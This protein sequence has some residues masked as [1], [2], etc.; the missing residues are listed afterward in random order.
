[1]KK[2]FNTI[3][4]LLLLQTASYAQ[5][6]A[7]RTA[8]TKIADVLAQQPAAEQS[9]F[10]AAMKELEG[11]TTEDVVTLL[12][13]LK[14]QGGNNASIE[15]ATNSYAFYVMQPGRDAL[16]EKY[17]KGLLSALSDLK[18]QN[19]KAYVFELLKF[20]AKNESVDQVATYLT[21]A[22]FAEKAARVLSAI[23]TPEAAL[24]LNK[25]LAGNVTEQTATAIIGALGELQSKEAEERVIALIG[26]YQ[27]ENFQRNALTTLSKIGGEK[28]YDTF[29]G[30]AKSANFAFD[31][32]NVA[33]LTL[34]YANVLAKNGHKD[35]AYKLSSAVFAE[36]ADPKAIGAQVAALE[37][38]SRLEPKKQKKNLL[39]LSTGDNVVLRNVALGLLGD[40]ATASDLKRIASSL[41]KLSPESQESVLSFLKK[42]DATFAIPVIEKSLRGVKD[43][44]ARIAAYNTLSA[45]TKGANT[46]FV[47]SQLATAS[48]KEVE[49]LK[50]LL[51]TAK[52]DQV[53]AEINKALPGADDKTK[54]AL[55][56]VLSKRSDKNS[57]KAVF[58]LIE[59]GSPEVR[60]AAYKA[61]PNVVND[62]DF[63][64]V[65]HVMGTAKGAEVKPAQSAAIVALRNNKD[66]TAI[67]QRLS[68]NISRSQAPSAARLFPV[69]AG[70]GGE[71][72]LKTV[73]GYLGTNNPLKGDAIRALAG[74][75]NASSL[76][77]L[78]TLLRTEKDATLFKDI[79]TGF[80]KQLNASKVNNE[81]KTLLLRDAFEYAQTKDQRSAALSGLKSTGTYPALIFASK[82]LNDA[83]L[84]GVA[85]DVV[86]NII[87]DN[88]EFVGTDVRNW[89][90][91]AKNNLSGSESS[92]LKEAI[93][94]HLTEMPAKEG[95]VALFNGKDLTGWKGLVENPIKRAKMTPKEL[96]QKQ[97]EADKKMRESWSA[98]DGDLVFS[99]HGDNIATVKQYGDFELLLDWKLDKNGKEPDAGV[100]LRGTPQVQIWDIS[101]TNVGAQVGSGGL[102][103]NKSNSKPLKVADNPLGEWNN[104]K[105]R[106]VGEDVSVWLNGELVVDNVPLENYWDRNQSIFPMEQIE[107]QAHGSRVWYRDVYLKE[108]PR[109]VV[110]TLSDQE[111]AEGFEMLFDGTNLDKWTSS[112][113][114]EINEEGVLRSNPAAKFGK[115]IY[116]KE[117]YGDF[118]YRFEFKL[119][120]G[121]NNGVGIR[122]PLEG[123][124]AYL[125]YE[126]QM[127]DDNAEVYSKLKPYQYH[128]SVYGIIAAKRGSLKPLGE[129]NEEEI[130]IQGSKIKVTVN[131]Q[132]VVDGDIKAATKEGPADGKKHPGLDTTAGHI[133]FLGHGTEVFLRNIRVKRL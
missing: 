81:Q 68:A 34:E 118:V 30:K 84:K 102:Y 83:E 48:G 104:F 36:A 29:Y 131:G 121:A 3:S 64:S 105:I 79:F 4:I 5:Q 58:A 129:W 101:R 77:E 31:K 54:I 49:A 66:K 55:L 12:K 17:A 19:N 93:V 122:A 32:S 1:M 108:L 92:Y 94:R 124:A 38:M 45:L 117:Q 35:L 23:H 59:T 60:A 50:T 125:G 22:Y 16:R 120:A 13:G 24:A 65:V 14:P 80:V 42:K 40:D 128:G 100:Y 28:S 111:K 88:K 113:A 130:R 27:S 112:P 115:N 41:T 96:E 76:G 126:I 2:I 91:V 8:A 82:Y 75:S 61:L 67:I 133:G 71:E 53:V 39:K 63:E 37:L 10:L 86:M 89:L 107:L 62:E 74:W 21:D 73:S 56:D 70:E 25:A 47:I 97:L 78:T 46:P 33:A 119:T 9:K 52:N 103:N 110:Y 44:E 15:Y 127:L 69:F 116:T 18:D 11:F 132:V 98:I 51:L 123:D 6:P 87:M 90:E 106:M 72:S 85:T 109:K 95:Y 57:A 26:Q 114:Y 7:N 43:P 99:G 20:C